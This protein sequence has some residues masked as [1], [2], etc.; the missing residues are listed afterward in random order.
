MGKNF[1]G[2]GM[3]VNVTGRWR[4]PGVADPPVPHIE[5]LVVLRLSRQSEG[6]ANGVAQADVCTQ[7]LVDAIDRHATYLNALTTTFV[8]RVA[9]PMTM[10][11]DQLAI[12]AALKTLS[13]SDLSRARVVRVKN[14]LHLEDLWLS[15][16]LLAEARQCRPTGPAAPLVFDVQGNLVGLQR[17]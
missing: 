3:D 15:E 6:N 10:A 9:L 12:S 8:E 17:G 5:R 4:L 1:S 16:N 11:S 14:T 7:A 2:T 13:S